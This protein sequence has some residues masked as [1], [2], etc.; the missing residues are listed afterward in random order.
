VVDHSSFSCV[1]SLFHARSA[2]T[3]KALSPIR[4]RVRGTTTS[5]DDEARSADR[6]DYCSIRSNIYVRSKADVK[7]LNDLDNKSRNWSAVEFI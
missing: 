5:P 3:E 1:S 7:Q 4:R 2:A 6:A